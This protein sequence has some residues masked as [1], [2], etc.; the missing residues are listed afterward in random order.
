MRKI[1]NTHELQDELRKLIAYT[2]SNRPSRERIALEL[3]TLSTRLASSGGPLLD[4]KVEWAVELGE[5]MKARFSGVGGWRDHHIN[6]D[7][8][9]TNSGCTVNLESP[10]GWTSNIYI[11][12]GEGE[13]A[14]HVY[15]NVSEP[16]DTPTGADGLPDLDAID[17]TDLIGK[18][19]RESFPIKDREPM[20]K[21][22]MAVSLWIS[23][24]IQSGR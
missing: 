20:A 9:R 8:H 6:I 21:A 7:M 16:K 12:M 17:L 18:Q 13:Q 14:V 22:M 3:K 23:K 10:L 2:G 5:L 19:K 4:A 11:E 24:Q 1:A 15:F